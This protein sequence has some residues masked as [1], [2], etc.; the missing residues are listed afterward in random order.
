MVVYRAMNT[1]Q[2]VEYF[3]PGLMFAESSSQKVET[4]DPAAIASKLPEGAY[5]FRFMERTEG[6]IDGEAVN[7][8]FKNHSGNY[9]PAGSVKMSLAEV[10]REMPNEEILISN[11]EG[12]KIPHVVKTV[13]GNIVAFN[14]GDKMIDDSNA[15]EG[16]L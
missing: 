4:R 1:Q 5:C 2:Y 14:D 11:M 3:Y 13:R 6:E 12:N 16:A 7:G 15:L 9:F 10:K 8:K